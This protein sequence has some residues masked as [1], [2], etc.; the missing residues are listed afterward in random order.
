[1]I[2]LMRGIPLVSSFQWVNRT[3]SLLFLTSNP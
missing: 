1:M 3:L 2:A